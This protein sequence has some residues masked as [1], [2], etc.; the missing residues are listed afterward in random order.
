MRLGKCMNLTELTPNIVQGGGATATWTAVS[1]SH[2]TFDVHFP[3]GRYCPDGDPDAEIDPYA[4]CTIKFVGCG[5]VHLTAAGTSGTVAGVPIAF[6]QLLLRDGAGVSIQP[7]ISLVGETGGV[8]CESAGL[9]GDDDVTFKVTCGMELTL[10][11]DG[12]GAG[13]APECDV[14]FTVKIEA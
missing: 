12:T 13:T 4:S 6:S 5:T 2:G 14:S 11:F 3:P 8:S 10:E 7:A 9:S 1:A